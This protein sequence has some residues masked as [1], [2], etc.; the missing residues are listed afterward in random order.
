MQTN[1]ESQTNLTNNESQT[2]L[3]NKQKR[4]LQVD[5]SV[6]FVSEVLQ[7]PELSGTSGEF[8][9]AFYAAEFLKMPFG[10]KLAKTVEPTKV[11][12]A[13]N[14]ALKTCL[15]GDLESPRV[16][17]RSLELDIFELHGKKFPLEVVNEKFQFGAEKLPVFASVPLGS[18]VLVKCD[19]SKKS[20][21]FVSESG[22]DFTA[23]EYSD[24][25]MLL[26]DMALQK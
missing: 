8:L 23:G 15:M 16:A 26:L 12:S 10:K 18:K 22:Q 4:Q 14:R 3:T 11:F 25:T 13:F 5:K 19:K 17:V 9:A 21:T 24:V 1:N 6:Q 20:L 2:N 7:K